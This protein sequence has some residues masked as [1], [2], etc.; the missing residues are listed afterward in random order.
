MTNDDLTRLLTAGDTIGLLEVD[1]STSAMQPPAQAEGRRREA[2]DALR[3]AGGDDALVGALL[4]AVAPVAGAVDPIGMVAVSARGAVVQQPLP[5]AAPGRTRAEVTA[6]PDLS[7]I[8]RGRER[9]V[10]VLAVEALA[11]GGVVRAYPTPGL[12]AAEQE[13]VT[14]EDLAVHE[15][16]ASG[17]S[18]RA[19]DGSADDALAQNARRLADRVTAAA[20]RWDASTVVV[21]GD[22]RSA[23]L[24]ATELQR[25]GDLTVAALGKDTAAAGA[26]RSDL[27]EA[28]RLTVDA[29]LADAHRALVDR[30]SAGGGRLGASGTAEVVA[31][32][33]GAAVDT[34]LMGP[35][36]IGG[37]LVALDAPPW[38]A[39]DEADALGA[40]VL[41]RFPAVAALT[42][43]ALLTDAAVRFPDP[44]VLP[45]SAAVAAHLRRPLDI[46][47][48]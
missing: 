22:P 26:D 29:L 47:E 35:D 24:L 8:L 38:I 36:G 15:A 44:G 14:G 12:P 45:G 17:I 2:E 11:A 43:A 23:E 31:A 4:P 13:E 25:G 1:V 46:E 34:L 33:Q 19:H 16:H 37:D 39:S 7:A 42:R 10:P 18:Q 30:L 5:G 41:G 21:L 28:V 32:L 9:A 6:V 20:R 3:A 40:G 27:T 48:D